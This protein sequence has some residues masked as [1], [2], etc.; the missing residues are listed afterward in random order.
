M[1]STEVLGEDD[2]DHGYEGDGGTWR[3]WGL[4]YYELARIGL[5]RPGH[6]VTTRSIIPLQPSGLPRGDGCVDGEH[7]TVP[8]MTVSITCWP[9]TST[10]D[11]VPASNR[12]SR[13]TS[14]GLFCSSL[15]WRPLMAERLTREAQRCLCGRRRNEHAT[16]YL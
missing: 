8:F 10:H 14:P 12:H 9:C 1:T 5:P 16:S 4:A 2:T 6:T 13:N 3:W 7:M 15:S 11:T